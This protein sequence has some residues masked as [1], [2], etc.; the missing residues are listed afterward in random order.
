MINC[1]QNRKK[2]E[3]FYWTLDFLFASILSEKWL[4]LTWPCNSPKQHHLQKIPTGFKMAV[5]TLK[6]GMTLFHAKFLMTNYFKRTHYQK[7]S[8]MV[9]KQASIACIRL[10]YESKIFR[11][12]RPEAS[13]PK[14]TVLFEARSCDMCLLTLMVCHSPIFKFISTSVHF[15]IVA[16]RSICVKLGVRNLKGTLCNTHKIQKLIAFI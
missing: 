16:D 4:D 13:L 11:S 14:L 2:L 5:L 8:V 3:L 1:T 12:L 7:N 9:S 15:L 6:F 10:V